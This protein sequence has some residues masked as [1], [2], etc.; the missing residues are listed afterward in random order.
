MFCLGPK[1]WPGLCITGN[2][3]SPI[4]IVTEDT[5]KTD[6]GALKFIRYDFAF[7]GTI[8]NN[9]H[10]GMY[11]SKENKLKFVVFDV[12]KLFTHKS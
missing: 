2:K 11:N 12:I 9:G 6:L 4:N 10:S 7:S 1:H 5:I 8:I 3:Q